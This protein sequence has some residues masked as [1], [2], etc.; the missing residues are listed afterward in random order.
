MDKRV[1]FAVAGAGKTTYI[2]EH[3]SL[4][5]RSLII[6]YTDNNYNNLQNKILKK[7]DGNWPENITLMTY[8]SFLL[9]F[10]YKPFLS[11]WVNVKDLYFEKN[12]NQYDQQTRISYYMTPNRYLYHNRL[13]L[14]LEKMDILDD[15]KARVEKYFDEFVI[16]EI[17]DIGGRDFNFLEKIIDMNVNILF[18]GDFYQHTY[19]TSRDGNVNSNLF[20]NIDKYEKRFVN[21]GF[22]VDKISLQKSWRCGEKICDFVR[23]HLGIVIYS[24]VADNDSNIEFV[25]DPTMIKNIIEDDRVIK[26]HYQNSAK[27]GWGHKNWGD[28]KGEDKYRDVC[29]MLNKSTAARYKN[30]ELDKLPIQTRNKLYVAITR[31][32]NNVYLINE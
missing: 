28:T 3:L 31:A 24:N 11:N 17:Q 21:K 20:D 9:S 14:L 22:V 18:V 12:P 8:F 26:L 1:I 27:L 5:K 30:S 13:S 15:I 4:Q 23:T 32:H 16:D 19:D 10:C 7:F 6:T 29:V 2:V 25:S